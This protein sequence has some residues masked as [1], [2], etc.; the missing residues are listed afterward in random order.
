MSREWIE[1]TPYEHRSI[2]VVQ[3]MDGYNTWVKR[4]ADITEEGKV[5]PFFQDKHEP[6]RFDNR[7]MIFREDGP[8]RLGTVGVWE[9]YAEAHRERRGEDHTHS[10]YVQD[11]S[12]VEIHIVSDCYH[13]D[14]LIARLRNG[15]SFAPSGERFLLCCS[16]GN[17]QLSGLLCSTSSMTVSAG[18]LMLADPVIFLPQYDFTRKDDVLLGNDRR[19]LNTVELGSPVT[20]VSVKAV[21]E[22]VLSIVLDDISWKKMKERGASRE[23]QKKFKKFLSQLS[24]DDLVRKISDIGQISEEEA[25]TELSKFISHAESYIEAASIEDEVLVACVQTNKDLQERCKALIA[26]DWE[27]ENEERLRAAHE[28]LVEK[29]EKCRAT[30]VQ[31]ERYRLELED[32]AYK[33]EIL[34]SAVAE[35]ER[36]ATEVEQNVAARIQRARENAA[37]F[38]AEVAFFPSPTGI[39]HESPAISTH[40]AVPF[41][42]G[43]AVDELYENESWKETLDALETALGDVGISDYLARGVAAYLYAARIRRIPVLIAG[44]H[45]DVI[46]DALSTSLCGRT[47]GRLRCTGAFDEEV[48]QAALSGSDEVIR[49]ENPLAHE[50]RSFLPTILANREKYWIAVHPFSEDLQLEPQGLFHYFLP[51]CTEFLVDHAAEPHNVGGFRAENYKEFPVVEKVERSY[52]KLAASLSMTPL[53]MENMALVLT[54]MGEMMERTEVVNADAAILFAL[55]PYAYA[56]GRLEEIKELFVHKTITLSDDHLKMLRWLIGDLS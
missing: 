22:I 46:A 2:C 41:R 50:W 20:R 49:I 24:G 14:D 51:I 12:P 9:W 38:L 44:A 13:I 1:E 26:A 55:L 54:N 56:T 39:G 53:F 16:L 6:S 27:A 47:C 15:I 21:H 48:V 43:K 52:Q 19:Y 42:A 35:Q 28:E 11:I 45:A 34:S 10:R 30:E 32:L 25:A 37:E 7:D 23:D 18:K 8:D 3:P 31:L 4:L 17:R 29:E 33:K 36:F 5:R 40:G